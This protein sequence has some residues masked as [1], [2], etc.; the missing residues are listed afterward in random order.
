MPVYLSPSQRETYFQQVWQV[1]RQIPPGQ[2]ATY[3]DIASLVE[4]PEGI[5]P[6]AY[7]AFSP[8]WVGGAMA[9]C[10]HDVPWQR[11]INAQGKIS[12]R[13]GSGQ[14]RQRALLEGEGIQFDERDRI[15]LQRYGWDGPDNQLRRSS[16]PRL[17]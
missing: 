3:G 12:L 7:R 15:D 10:P 16:Q 8:R 5:D 1:V 11:V 4:P 6:G 9:A 2:V 14:E 13:R 17:F